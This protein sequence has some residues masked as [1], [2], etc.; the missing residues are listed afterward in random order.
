[1]IIRKVK[2]IHYCIVAIPTLD[3]EAISIFVMIIHKSLL[4][5]SSHGKSVSLCMNSC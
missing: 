4:L 5:M 1:M 2:I 3:R